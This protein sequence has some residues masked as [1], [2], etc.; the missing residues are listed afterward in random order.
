[1]SVARFL[2]QRAVRI[3][4]VGS[5]TLPNWYDPE[6]KLRSFAC[7]TTRVSPFRALLDVPV[8]GKIGD[9]LTSYFREFGK[10]E[11]QIS[12]TVHGGFLLE[13]EMTRAE[14]AKLAEKLVWLEKRQRDPT[15]RDARRDARYVP[16]SPHSALMLADGSSIPCL[17]IDASVSGVAVSSE[18]QPEIGTP[19]AVGSCVG[20]VVRHFHDGFAVRFVDPLASMT[21]LERRVVTQPTRP[22]RQRL[23]AHADDIVESADE[24]FVV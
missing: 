22:T 24:F 14:R 21:E 10:F 15:I 3:Q 2:K 7:R 8:V 1:M 13:L 5:Y 6:G 16:D 20:R 17:V 11:G 19:L 23:A 12:D 9:R 18:L 4:T